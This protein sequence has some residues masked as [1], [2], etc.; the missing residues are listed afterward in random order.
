M[1][2]ATDHAAAADQQR[3]LGFLDHVQKDIYVALVGLGLLGLV[4]HTQILNAA[5]AAV[6]LPV[7]EFIFHQ[8]VGGGDIL[9]EVNQNRTGTTTGGH[10]KSL[11]HHIGDLLCIAHQESR[12][13]D[14]HGDTGG[15]DLLKGILTQQVLA[16]IAGDKY[17]GGGIQI[18]SGDAG[19][20]VR[21]AGAGGGEADAHLA[22]GAGIT[23][24]RVSR[25]LLVGG[26]NVVEFTLVTVEF[27][28]QVQDGAA[29]IAEDGI[30]VLL[31]QALHDR[32]RC[33]D[34]QIAFLLT[35][36]VKN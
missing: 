10:G 17:H 26:Q 1:G 20:Q 14:R 35:V 32:L 13:G 29:G 12:L 11:A 28:V 34:F 23:V 18:G 4:D 36:K 15:V 25:A 31:Q 33:G 7:D 3:L 9:Q 6:F 24:S 2:T 16:H 19:G 8:L 21:G 27:I 30:Y 5:A 22:G